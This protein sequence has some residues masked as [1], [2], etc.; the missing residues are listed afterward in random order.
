M[1]TLHLSSKIKI[2][3]NIVYS[4]IDNKEL[5]I[6]TAANKCYSVSTLGTKVWFLLASTSMTLEKICDHIQEFY[7][8][9]RSN[10]ITDVSE[11]VNAMA[12]ND[13]LMI[14]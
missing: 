10:C 11:F 9:E 5:V 1:T 8:V 4:I 6:I 14:M 13:I 12:R 3:P 2:N 7:D